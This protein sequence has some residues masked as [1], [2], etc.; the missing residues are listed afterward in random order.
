MPKQSLCSSRRRSRIGHDGSVPRP[1]NRCE[2]E[3]RRRSDH[4]LVDILFSREPRRDKREPLRPIVLSRSRVSNPPPLEDDQGEKR[5][6]RR[7]VGLWFS[8]FRLLHCL[9]VPVRHCAGIIF[10][11]QLP[12][13]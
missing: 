13:F 2:P 9:R 7:W 11:H 5:A 3:T 1:L 8:L 4:G 12:K 6:L 10:S